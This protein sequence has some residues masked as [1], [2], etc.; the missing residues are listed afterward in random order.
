MI[1][2]PVLTIGGLIALFLVLG[3][4]FTQVSFA[5]IG[6]ILLM[7]LLWQLSLRIGPYKKC[8][9]C[10]GK[11]YLG[12]WLGGRRKCPRCKTS[13]LLPRIGSGKDS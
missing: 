8:W 12:G 10:A 3:A 7:L 9:R 4:K 13:G 6:V 5:V 2:G 11:G 1:V